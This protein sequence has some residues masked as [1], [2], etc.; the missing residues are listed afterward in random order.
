MMMGL[1]DTSTTT[2]TTTA[3]PT[4]TTGLT[5]WESPSVAFSTIG[6]IL[7]N[8]TTAFSSALLPFSAGV[9]LPPVAVAVL[10]LMNMGGKKR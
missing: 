7:T 5:L 6:T 1:G 3:I 9:L 4:F 10:I 8:P 2:T